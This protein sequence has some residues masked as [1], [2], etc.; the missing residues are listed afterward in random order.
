MTRSG[1]PINQLIGSY[2]Y[3]AW[4]KITSRTE[5]YG[6]NW[7]EWR[8]LDQTNS[9]YSGHKLSSQP[10]W[11]EYDDTV[12]AH[13]RRQIEVSLKYGVDFFTYLYY[14][15]PKGIDLLPAL[16]TYCKVVRGSQHQFS[17]IWPLR[18]PRDRVI[19]KL[20]SSVDY[21]ANREFVLTETDFLNCISQTTNN[22]FSHP[23][24]LK[25]DDKP[26]LYLY[27]Y[28]DFVNRLG[29]KKF[30]KCINKADLLLKQSGFKGLY[31]IGCT[32][33]PPESA[34]AI[35]ELGLNALS[36]YVLLP[37]FNHG[38]PI[39]DY[40]TQ[41]ATKFSWA[42]KYE[43]QSSLPYYQSIPVGFDASPRGESG[44][45]IPEQLTENNY[46]PWFPIVEKRSPEI[47]E[48]FLRKALQRCS[49]SGQ[50]ILNIASWNEWTQGHYLEPDQEFQFTYLEIIRRLKSVYATTNESTFDFADS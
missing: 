21:E 42:D 23:N 17:L 38:N 41:I 9:I 24:Y 19:R 4:H 35:N 37:D 25:I 50:K 14:W 49:N 18:R 29:F 5:I 32:E 43:K 46:Y 33:K 39:Q 10:L 11:G 6:E 2:V 15:N 3:P 20:N 30:R 22:F 31:L 45:T 44:I 48:K 8:L 16:K 7:T 26:V 36:S 47:F 34:K 40:T 27:K 28:F 13:V 12:E 1:R